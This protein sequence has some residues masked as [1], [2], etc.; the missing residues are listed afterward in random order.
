ML[1]LFLIDCLI[2]VSV[3]I[4]IFT[5]SYAEV[6]IYSSLAHVEKLFTFD[7]LVA[8]TI[9]NLDLPQTEKNQWVDGFVIN[10]CWNL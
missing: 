4:W 6:D 1:N 2:T 3:F 8:K 10:E 9:L 5:S 7:Q